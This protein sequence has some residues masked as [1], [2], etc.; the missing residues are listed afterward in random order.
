[1]G[2]ICGS[3]GG[4]DGVKGLRQSSA[5]LPIESPS[6][7]PAHVGAGLQ[8]VVSVP[9]KDGDVGDTIGVVSNLLDEAEPP[10]DLLEPRLAVGGCGEVPSC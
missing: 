2:L 5:L 7:V 1:V 10:L 6:L 3:S 8:H 4:N 9:S